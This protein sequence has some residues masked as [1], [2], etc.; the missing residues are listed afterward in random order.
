MELSAHPG[1]D[2]QA[3]AQASIL[4]VD[5]HELNVELIRGILA[6]HHCVHSAASGAAAISFCER[7]P[8]I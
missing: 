8:L 4:V 2:A 7:T 3:L 5:D 6:G 1:D